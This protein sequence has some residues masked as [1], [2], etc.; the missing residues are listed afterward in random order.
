MNFF[1]NVDKLLDKKAKVALKIYD[2]KNKWET[3]DYNTPFATA[4]KKERQPDNETW[5]V[6]TK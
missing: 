3:N 4:L 1:G 2:V 6:N 5:L